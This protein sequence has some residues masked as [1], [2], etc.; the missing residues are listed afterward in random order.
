MMFMYCRWENSAQHPP[1]KKIVLCLRDSSQNGAV[2]DVTIKL[3]ILEAAI[4]LV[5]KTTDAA[6]VVQG[7]AQLWIQLN[8]DV[9]ATEEDDDDDAVA[10]DGVQEAEA[11][12]RW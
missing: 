2:E 4:D 12:D 5:I 10:G 6:D 9:D 11:V 8:W 1:G 7:D 3:E